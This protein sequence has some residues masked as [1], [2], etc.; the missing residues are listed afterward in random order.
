MSESLL[1]LTVIEIIDNHRECWDQ[2]PS[3]S[4]VVAELRGTNGRR[5]SGPR[6]SLGGN[7]HQMLAD[8]GCVLY[9]DNR[10]VRV[11]LEED[12]NEE[13]LV[14]SNPTLVPCYASKLC[15]EDGL[16]LAR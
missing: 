6:F 15:Q 16:A 13:F 12:F 7:Y 2:N 14:D 9:Y 8:L 1:A 11:G 10:G 5:C 4:H 3:V